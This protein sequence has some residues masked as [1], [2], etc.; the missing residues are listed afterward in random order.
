VSLVR[1]Y[2]LISAMQTL[3]GRS[4]ARGGRARRR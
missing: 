3:A 1:L 2:Y 4:R